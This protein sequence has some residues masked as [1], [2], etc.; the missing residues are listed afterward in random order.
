VTAPDSWHRALADLLSGSH[1]LPPD[2]LPSAPP[3][4]ILRRLGQAVAAHQDGP[5]RDDATLLLLEWS[6][7]SAADSAP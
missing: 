5:L 6:P 4:E 1:R 7:A 3:A 2:E